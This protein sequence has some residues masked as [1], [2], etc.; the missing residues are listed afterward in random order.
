MAAKDNKPWLRSAIFYARRYIPGYITTTSLNNN[1]IGRN[2]VKFNTYDQSGPGRVRSVY[3]AL[4]KITNMFLFE[5]TQGNSIGK[6][7]LKTKGLKPLSGVQLEIWGYNFSEIPIN[8]PT[9]NAMS[10]YVSGSPGVF[11]ESEYVDVNRYTLHENLSAANPDFRGI[12]ISH[13]KIPVLDRTRSVTSSIPSTLNFTT[14]NKFRMTL[15]SIYNN[16][17]CIDI[18]VANAAGYSTLNTLTKDYICV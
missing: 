16:R 14:K 3:S 2:V 5:A 8:R 4:P 18:I 7:S 6:D 9:L 13:T 10:V 11:D 1:I 12:P 15:P 17:G